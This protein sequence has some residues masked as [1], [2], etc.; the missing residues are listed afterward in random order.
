MASSRTR[1]ARSRPT[2][3]SRSR[4]ASPVG[5]AIVAAIVAVVIGVP[6]AGWNLATFGVAFLPGLALATA[7]SGVG[8][9]RG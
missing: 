2:F 8:S 1:R 6:G 3:R 9:R 4:S 7:I 5:C